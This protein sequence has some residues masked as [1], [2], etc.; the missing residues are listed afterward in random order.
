MPPGTRPKVSIENI[1]DELKLI[2]QE[3]ALAKDMHVFK[4]ELLKKLEAKHE[5][6][7]KLKRQTACQR[8]HNKSFER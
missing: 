7:K 3:M 4:D 5:E 1:L 2:R 8:E 6:I